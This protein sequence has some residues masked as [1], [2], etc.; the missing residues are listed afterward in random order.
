ML[1]S[2]WTSHVCHNQKL[3]PVARTPNHA[4]RHDLQPCCPVGGKSHTQVQATPHEPWPSQCFEGHVVE[5]DAIPTKALFSFPCSIAPSHFWQSWKREITT[6]QSEKIRQWL[7]FSRESR[8]TV[9]LEVS[10]KVTWQLTTA[11]ASTQS[12]HAFKVTLGQENAAC[13]ACSA[14]K[15]SGR[16][17]SAVTNNMVLGGVQRG[18]LKRMFCQLCLDQILI[19]QLHHTGRVVDGAAQDGL[20]CIRRV[21][22]LNCGVYLHPT[23]RPARCGGWLS[24][25]QPWGTVAKMGPPS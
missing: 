18:G 11:Q 2:M 6:A 10:T 22:A 19:R 15:M 3:R 20:G 9:R 21:V 5:Q 23:V 4:W 1:Q 24:A 12:I 17:Q 7:N 8:R 13:L 14:A 16:P 25:L